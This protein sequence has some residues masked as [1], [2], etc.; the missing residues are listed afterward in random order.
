MGKSRSAGII[1]PPER[2]FPGNETKKKR[3]KQSQEMEREKVL[4]LLF[5]HLDPA[6]P[7]ATYTCNFRLHQQINLLFALSQT[8]LVFCSEIKS[9][10]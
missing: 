1:S 9:H 4:A 7:E 2:G 8:E 5:E 3:K 10:D 6:L